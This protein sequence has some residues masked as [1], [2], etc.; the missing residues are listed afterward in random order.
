MHVETLLINFVL[1][2][3]APGLIYLKNRESSLGEPSQINNSIK[4][5]IYFNTNKN[6][7]QIS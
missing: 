7:F 6:F 2:Y 4:V 3:G 1:F 5:L